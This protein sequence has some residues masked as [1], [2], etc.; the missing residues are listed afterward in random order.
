MIA[1]EPAP[2][3]SPAGVTLRKREFSSFLSCAT[4]AVGLL[5]DVSVLLTTDER[6]RALNQQ[7]RGLD[8]A[9]DVL[10]FPAARPFAEEGEI[11]DMAISWETARRQAKDNNHSL[12]IEIK[13]LML[14]GL[15]HLAGHD[16]ETDSGQMATRETELRKQ[17]GL[18]V[19]LI[20]RVRRERRA[21]PGAAAIERGKAA[22]G[23][24]PRR[25]PS[26]KSATPKHGAGVHQAKARPSQG[27]RPE[28]ARRP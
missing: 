12:P 16:H 5:G 1:I 24:G 15:L 17:L 18:P 7:F 28:R 6:V 10:S 23:N 20:E 14:H 27:H 9:T 21:R 26:T 8:K 19:G 22:A 11:G 2:S 25:K 4:K 13:I 3:K